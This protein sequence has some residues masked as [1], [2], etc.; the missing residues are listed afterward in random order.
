[1]FSLIAMLLIKLMQFKA[2]IKWPLWMA[3]SL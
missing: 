2:A 1:M 3:V